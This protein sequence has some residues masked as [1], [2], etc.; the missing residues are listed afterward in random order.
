MGDEVRVLPLAEIDFSAFTDDKPR[1]VGYS[2]KWLE[3]SFEF[4]N[5]PRI[6]PAPISQKIA[7]N[8][9]QCRP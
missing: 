2:A 1:I 4:Q 3:D 5:T 8:V 7:Q 9:R 6:I